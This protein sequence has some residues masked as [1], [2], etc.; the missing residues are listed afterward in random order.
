MVAYIPPPPSLL[1][2][3]G[4]GEVE[5]PKELRSPVRWGLVLNRKAFERELCKGNSFKLVE[6]L[7]AKGAASHLRSFPCRNLD[8]TKK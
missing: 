7:G 6:V 2:Y 1:L 5:L 3:E 4:V 8:V